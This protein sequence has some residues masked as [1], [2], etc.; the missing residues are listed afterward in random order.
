MPEHEHAN[1]ADKLEQIIANPVTRSA[2]ASIISSPRPQGWGRKS[3][4]TYFKKVY[5]DE[6]IPH[7][8]S[9]IE[10]GKDLIFRYNVW[11]QQLHISERTLY[12]RFNQAILF[13]LER[14]DPTGKYNKWYDSVDIDTKS[15]SLGIVFSVVRSQ[16]AQAIKP[17][18]IEPAQSLPKWRTQLADWLENDESDSFVREHLALSPEDITKLRDEFMGNEGLMVDIKSHSIKIVKV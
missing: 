12:T 6:L 17:E 16:M 1:V 10:S 8:D 4:A 11:C 15:N 7:I 5:A 13:L 2:I 9:Q 18:L 3:T 14:L